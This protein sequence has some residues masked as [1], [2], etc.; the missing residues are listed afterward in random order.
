MIIIK[1]HDDLYRV[2]FIND[3]VGFTAMFPQT[4]ALNGDGQDMATKRDKEL[5]FTN[6]P[7]QLQEGETLTHK[8]V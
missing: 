2:N 8:E 3:Q 5:F 6:K 7:D 1:D 4:Y